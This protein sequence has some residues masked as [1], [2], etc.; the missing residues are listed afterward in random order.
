MDKNGRSELGA[1]ICLILCS[2]PS[3]FGGMTTSDKTVAI[4]QDDNHKYCSKLSNVTWK[5]WKP[6]PKGPRINSECLTW[7]T[8]SEQCCPF[9]VYVSLD[10]TVLPYFLGFWYLS[11]ILQINEA[12]LHWLTYFN[13][14]A[15]SLKKIYSTRMRFFLLRSLSHTELCL[16]FIP[17]SAAIYYI[18]PISHLL[19]RHFY[20]D[21]PVS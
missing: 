8:S 19:S 21:S 18:S 4:S 3:Y 7:P 5:F 12:V 2:I 14:T 15:E 11:S 9:S 6:G 13:M 20:L 10:C 17:P 1:H 16:T